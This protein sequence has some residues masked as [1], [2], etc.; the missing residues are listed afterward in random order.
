M[1]ADNSICI[2]K[3]PKRGGSNEF[4]YRVRDINSIH[5]DAYDVQER[6]Q[7]GTDTQKDRDWIVRIFY[8]Y[9][10][11][12]PV[13]GSEDEAIAESERLETNIEETGGYIEHGDTDLEFPWPF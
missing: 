13:F 9:F 1:S 2:L 12:R 6:V 5:F 8:P 7:A 11:N 10:K 4:E 3:T